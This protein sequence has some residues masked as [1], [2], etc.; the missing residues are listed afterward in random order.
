[1][2]FF[3]SYFQQILSISPCVLMNIYNQK[4]KKK[5]AR[6]IALTIQIHH[7]YKILCSH[8]PSITIATVLASLHH[9]DLDI[10]PCSKWYLAAQSGATVTA[11]TPSLTDIGFVCKHTSTRQ[12][13]RVV[14][15]PFPPN[16]LTK[17]CLP[18]TAVMSHST[19]MGLF[20]KMYHYIWI[21]S[22]VTK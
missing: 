16:K 12:H 10:Q 8:L 19:V 7:T 22:K 3:G 15:S 20:K 4:K 18:R 2:L 17:G 11:N 9:L 13:S 21:N 14:S 5:K 1:M 6:A